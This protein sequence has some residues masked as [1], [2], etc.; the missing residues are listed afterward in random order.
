MLVGVF[1][2]LRTRLFL[3]RAQAVKGTVIE[4]VY[5]RSTSS[6]GGGGGGYAP[7]YQ[8]MTSDGQSIVKQDSVA[9][10]PP[11]FQIGQEI[12]VLYESGKPQKARI[13]K[14]MNLYFLPTLLWGI[15]L[16]F[17]GVGVVI[18]LG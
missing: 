15:G 2:L 16:I 13:N 1:L 14:W 3:G 6:D 10:N 12:D 7:V 11:R 18:Q 17:I 8:F 5:R 4:M 9:S